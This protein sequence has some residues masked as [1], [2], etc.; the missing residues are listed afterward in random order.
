MNKKPD[1]RNLEIVIE[2]GEESWEKFVGILAGQI[3]DYAEKQDLL[4]K[5]NEVGKIEP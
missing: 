2:Y 5:K 1:L 3:L 4:P